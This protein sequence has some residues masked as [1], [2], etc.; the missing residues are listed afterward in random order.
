MVPTLNKL[1]I[2]RKMSFNKDPEQ[3]KLRWAF[4]GGSWNLSK[5][6]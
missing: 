2:A 6:V 4:L 3:E 5:K 1:G